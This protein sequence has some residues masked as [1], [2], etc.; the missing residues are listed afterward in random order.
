MKHWIFD[1]DGTLVDSF[2]SYTQV[3]TEVAHHFGVILSPED[4]EQ[5]RHLILPKFLERILKPDQIELASQKVIAVNL[6][7]QAEIPVFEGIVDLLIYLRSCGCVLSVFTARERVTTHGILRE[8]GLHHYFSRVVTRDC[9][10]KSK[11]HPDGIHRILTE[12]NT[13]PEAAV[14]IGDHLMDMQS[15]K[16]AG[17][18]GVSVSWDGEHCQAKDFSNHHFT[19]IRELRLWAAEHVGAGSAL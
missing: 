6:Q 7:Q 10:T 14:M 13:Q 8:T 15:A 18:R 16:S 1:L 3:L 4:K 17:I 11:P 9:I 12:S 2:P 19:N 5:V